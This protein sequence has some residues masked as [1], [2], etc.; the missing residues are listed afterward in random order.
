[1][2]AMGVSIKEERDDVGDPMLSFTTMNVDKLE[3]VDKDKS[4]ADNI[5]DMN[6]ALP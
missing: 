3:K 1:M 4:V 2:K 5:G 6:V